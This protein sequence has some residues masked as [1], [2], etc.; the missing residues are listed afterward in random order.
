MDTYLISLSLGPVQS[1][2]AAARRTR[3]LWTGSWL[4]SEASRAAARVIHQAHPNSL[5]FPAPTDPDTELRPQNQPGDNANIANIIRAQ[6]KCANQDEVRALC[7][8]A[9]A[10]ARDYLLRKGDDALRANPGLRQDQWHAQIDDILEGFAAWV[11]IENND[12][13]TASQ[14]LGEALAARKATRDCQPVKADG[15]GLPKS[16]L[17]GA[18]ETVLPEK[19]SR[20]LQRK[21]F[22]Q[23]GE[24]LDA[25]GVLKRHAGDVDQFTAYS[26]L[27]ADAW[28]EHLDDDSRKALNQ[29]YEPLVKK[30]LATRVK[31]NQGIYD[32][33]PYDAQL[34][35]DF[36]LDNAIGHCKADFDKSLGED[37]EGKEKLQQLQQALKA[38]TKKFGKPVPYAV[39]LQ[40]DGDRMGALL[41]KAESAVHSRDISRAL[42]GFAS[43][44]R[45]IVRE[46]RGHAIYSGGDD[47]LALLPL[48]TAVDAAKA[49][50]KDFHSAMAPMAKELGL[51]ED[52][53]P[54]LSVGLGIGHLIEPLG[55]LR[56][57][58]LLAERLAKGDGL[59]KKQQRNAL[60]IILGVR[61]G[62]DIGWRI[63]WND[64]DVLDDLDYFTKAYVKHSIPSRVAYDLRDIDLRLS[65][66]RGEEDATSKGMVQAE[67]ARMLERARTRSG[68]RLDDDDVKKRIRER[69]DDDDVKER[70]LKR[71]KSYTL[72]E[73]ADSLI[74]ARWLAAR[75]LK[76]VENQ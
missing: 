18:Y 21:L 38:V 46:H 68:E 50:A 72:A 20:Q 40:A 36:R 76:D 63:R 45:G 60:G 67:V 6:V 44:V 39:I 7:E 52:E 24:Q 73:F 43:S 54:T 34:L 23:G 41:Q 12:Y 26:R 22:L 4:L 14:R 59:D 1:L 66:L 30:E 10:A 19:P 74:I 69:M 25:L 28:I 13:V 47:V 17:D 57:R 15:F 55:N 5:I 37:V 53:Q 35:Y 3:D 49:L 48:N 33:L 31:G 58:A 71:T 2:I 27:A 75:T 51:K 29:A 65:W 61:S 64:K 9:K 56:Q 62:T 16:S 70:I 32:K 42:H 8:K 11:R